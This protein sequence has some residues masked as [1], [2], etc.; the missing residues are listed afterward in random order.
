VS[1]VAVRIEDLGKRYFIGGVREP[2]RSIR[3]AATNALAAP[4]RRAARV[5]RGEA[6]GASGLDQEVWALR[7]VCAEIGRGEAVGIIGRNGAGKTTLLKILSRITTPTEGQADIFGR[8]GSLLEVGT[9]FHPELTGAENIYLNGAIL[10]M[11]RHEIQRR[12]DEIVEFAELAKFINTP[13]KLYSSGMYVRLAFAVAAHLEPEILIVDEVLAVGDSSFQNKCLGRMGAVAR[14]GRTVLFVSHNMA[15][16]QNLTSRCLLFAGGRMTHVGPTADV[17]KDYLV[18]ILGPQAQDGGH[19]ADWPD[20]EGT[21][22]A[23]VTRLELL[24]RRGEP[25]SAVTFDQPLRLRLTCELGDELEATFGVLVHTLMQEPLLDLR[26]TEGGLVPQRKRGT[27]VV[28]ADVPAL[29]LY[30]GQY[31]LSPWIADRMAK[32]DIDFVHFCSKLTVV[33]PPEER[34]RV[35]D[36]TWGRVVVDSAWRYGG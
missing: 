12:F 11:K 2:S 22:Q 19:V 3:E 1:T 5:L 31:L 4:F 17:I 7:D 24:D 8:V 30:P 33:A 6:A 13:V 25:V 20:R 23:R 15:A 18:G 36:P 35:L 10:G 26:S 14:E 29:R 34:P 21:G 32:S 16:I 27:V 28:E 9:G